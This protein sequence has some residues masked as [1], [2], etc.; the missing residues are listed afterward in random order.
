[1]EIIAMQKTKLAVVIAS[2]L[3]GAA[4]AQAERWIGGSADSDGDGQLSQA[5]MAQV[6]PSLSANFTAMDVNNDKKLTRDE[7]TVW[8]DSLR[9]KIDAD[10]PAGS[11]AAARA[12]A[13][14]GS[15]PNV[16]AA[17]SN[18]DKKSSSGS[19]YPNS[20]GIVGDDPAKPT[21][22]AVPPDIKDKTT[23]K[24]SGPADQWMDSGVDTDGDG[25]LSQAELTK[26]SP[27]LSASFT[28]M[29]VD[30]DQKVTLD[31]FRSWHESL[32]TRMIAE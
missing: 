7:F 11:A 30:N 25:S 10:Q 9:V 31:E 8:H 23:N 15:N 4:A 21:S 6:A 2:M 3:L 18:V 17:G 13:D 5:E 24:D 22:T 26:V 28:D 12:D 27:T 32:K 16:G 1:V 29:D 14:T 20:A 19:Y